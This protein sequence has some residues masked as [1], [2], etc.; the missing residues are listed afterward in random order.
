M[1]EATLSDLRHSQ[2]FT[3]CLEVVHI[4]DDRKQQQIGYFIPK[5]IA[6]D[7]ERFLAEYEATK[8]LTLLKQIAQAQSKDAIGDGAVDDG[9]S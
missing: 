7:F 8:K 5:A 2:H 3:E 9:L 4:V 1:I 6:G